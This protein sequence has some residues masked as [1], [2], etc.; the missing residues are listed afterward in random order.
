M[1][2][3]KK[4]FKWIISGLL[5]C[6][7]N[8]LLILGALSGACALLS[9]NNGNS[10]N[11]NLIANGCP[12]E[13][14]EYFNTVSQMFN[15]PNWVLAAVAKKESSFNPDA[16]GGGAYGLMQLQRYDA[17]GS[18]LWKGAM[19]AGLDD[20]Y[21]NANYYYDSYDEM[22]NIYLEDPEA[23]IIGGA[24]WIRYYA[25]YV[26]Y[27][28]EIVE[29]LDYN[30]SE[31][32]KIINWNSDEDDEEFKEVLRRI[33]ACY[34]G[35]PSYGFKVDLDEAQNNYPNDVF[36]FAMEFRGEGI[37]VDNS[38]DMI[39]D[40]ETIEEA[41]NSGME[42]VGKSPYKWGGGR[43]EEDIE[44][45]IFDCSSFVHYCYSKAGIELGS[46]GSVTTYTLIN[47]GEK[48]DKED[49]QRGDII[50]FNTTGENSHVAIY[51]GNNKFLHD[52]TTNG[53]S[54]ASLDNSYYANAFNG[55]V[56]RIVE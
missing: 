20:M 45:G 39:G 51:L 31:N 54:I 47:L 4:F 14:V 30:N 44:N 55:E 16:V 3:L 36:R 34:N 5:A 21:K 17:D 18:D 22:W 10:F 46:V 1:S 43:T 13:L 19:R 49:I 23:Q 6:L 15:V 8:V 37:L 42:W 11:T 35:G 33:F 40:D 12:E 38:D 27:K 25:N 28:K 53:V 9:S 48:V 41:I 2:I 56:R 24:F 29:H 32:M 52:G 26:L 50:F 7:L